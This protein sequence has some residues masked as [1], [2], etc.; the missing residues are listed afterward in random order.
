MPIGTDYQHWDGDERCGRTA[1]IS[2]ISAY[3]RWNIYETCK[4]LQENGITINPAPANGYMAFLSGLP[5]MCRLN[6]CKKDDRLRA[7]GNRWASNGK[8]GHW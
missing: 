5:T 6:C 1:A 7:A 8:T 4:M 2:A 3:N